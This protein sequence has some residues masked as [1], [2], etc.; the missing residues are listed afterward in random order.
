MIE[1]LTA[2]TLYS[3]AGSFLL[4]LVITTLTGSAR[5]I[6]WLLG[7]VTALLVLG[8]LGGLWFTRGI[9][10]LLTFQLV[11]FVIILYFF[12]ILGALCG[13]GLHQ[14]LN[15]RKRKQ[16]LTEAEL[17]S[18]LTLAEFCQARGID[19][20]RVLPLLRSGFYR[21]GT[22]QGRWYVHRDEVANAAATAPDQPLQAFAGKRKAS[23]DAA[24]ASGSE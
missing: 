8:L 4:G 22:Y 15:H 2:A 10:I 20:P 21:G 5:S 13:A 12:V 11:V 9:L 16:T 7:I 3:I 19:E 18:H 6:R 1:L 24:S 17:S 23:E 14:L